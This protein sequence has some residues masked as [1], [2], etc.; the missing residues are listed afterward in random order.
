MQIKVSGAINAGDLVCLATGAA[1]DR[2]LLCWRYGCEAV[3]I[4]ART[5]SEDELVEYVPEQSTEDILVKGSAISTQD[6][7]VKIKVACDLKAEDLVCIRHQAGDQ[8]FVD[9]WQIG[10][11]AVGIAARDI[12]SDEV[13]EFCEGESTEDIHVKPS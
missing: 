2:L 12:N 6:K 8:F 3:G 4:A 5:F 11:E 1:G 10:D 7:S 13:V 9:K